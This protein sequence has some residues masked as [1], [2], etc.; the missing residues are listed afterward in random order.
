VHAPGT[1]ATA[2]HDGALPLRFAGFLLSN[3][4]ESIV[5]RELL[6]SDGRILF[7]KGDENDLPGIRGVRGDFSRREEGGRVFYDGQL[8][9]AKGG[10]LTLD[11]WPAFRLDSVRMQVSSEEVE[12]LWSRFTIKDDALEGERSSGGVSARGII[13][14]LS[15]APVE[16]RLSVERL[17]LVTIMPSGM[18]HFIQGYLNAKE[19]L[20]TWNTSRPMETWKLTGPVSL[21][22]CKLRALSIVTALQDATSGELQ[23]VNLDDCH[24]NLE[25]SPRGVV[26]REIRAAAVGKLQASGDLMINDKGELD[27]KF[28]I[29][30]SSELLLGRIPPV[31]ELGED[32]YYWV[33]VLV[34]GLSTAPIED[35]SARI[36]AWKTGASPEDS[37]RPVRP[38]RPARDDGTGLLPTDPTGS[39]VSGKKED[40]RWEGLFRSLTED[41][42]KDGRQP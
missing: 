7:G 32:G 36:L 26:L 30:L 8:S 19:L 35:L 42:K 33:N 31:L 24:F 15:N 23:G 2:A 41:K 14:T 1:L 17:P 38:A 4:P 6:V 27:G 11:G 22:L 9:G 28:R 10:T 18:E 25:M 29:G 34:G 39:S 16:L 13:P 3:K 12:V 40:E 5:F 21:K 20:L 37:T